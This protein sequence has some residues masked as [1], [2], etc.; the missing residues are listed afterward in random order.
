MREFLRVSQIQTLISAKNGNQDTIRPIAEDGEPPPGLL[1]N[2]NHT[3]RAPT[4]ATQIA[5]NRIQERVLV[6]PATAVPFDRFNEA[7]AITG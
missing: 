2:V 7:H 3:R 5:T 6:V 1:M 4:S